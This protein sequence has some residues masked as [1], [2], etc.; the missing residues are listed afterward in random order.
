MG[1]RGQ[2]VLTE[3]PTETAEQGVYN[4]YTNLNLRYSQN[5]PLTM[6]EKNTGTNLPAQ[7]ELYAD[8]APGHE[9]T[10]K[11]M[12]MAKGGGSAN[13]TFLFQETKALL[14]EASLMRFL[15]KELRG[16][17][18]SAC[19]PYHLAIVV[20]GTS[21]EFAL[22]TAKYAS[23]K[24]LDTLPTQ[25][26]MSAHAFRDLEMEEKVLKL[27]QDFGIGAQ[28]GGKYFCHDVR[29]IRLPRHGASLPV[30]VA[31]SCSADRQC[32]AKITPEGAFIEQLEFE[33]AVH[34]GHH[35]GRPRG[36]CCGQVDLSKPMSEILAEPT[37]HPVNRLSLTGT[38]VVAR[39]IAHAKIRSA[40]TPARRCRSTWGPPGLLRGPR[41]DAGGRRPAR[42]VRPPQDAWTP[43]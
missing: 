23:A 22:K 31:V 18:T 3:E 33:P 43:T 21:A 39:D 32:L 26:S 24:Y 37:K 17:G 16:L 7:I 19:P 38:V 2:H 1:K 35:R 29:V 4:A 12:F 10:Y 27:T 14:N 5:A 36:R 20:G 11:L 30:A 28:F 25:G 13:K 41:Q 15:D 6:W 40:W 34:A 9:M 42:S 8:T